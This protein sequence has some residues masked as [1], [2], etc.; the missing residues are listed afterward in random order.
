MRTTRT[1]VVAGA[2]IGGLTAALSLARAGY[3][4][5]VAERAKQL[6][7]GGAG[8]QL[9]PN[10]GRVLSELGLDEALDAAAVTPEAIEIRN[11]RSGAPIATIR[12]GDTVRKRHG[13][14]YRVVHRADLI[15]IL[16][17]AASDQPDVEVM[18]GAELVEFAAH[19]NGVTVML[20]TA[21]RQ[22]ELRASVLVAADGVNST[23]RASL[24]GASPPKATGRTAW[25][26]MLPLVDIPDHVPRNRTGLWLG[27]D[28]HL[29]HYPLRGGTELNIV[30]IVKDDQPSAGWNAPGDPDRLRRQLRRWSPFAQA[31]LARASGWRTW[32]ILAAS[33]DGPWVSGP[34]ALVGDAAHAMTPF[35]AQGGA[36]AI[37]DAAV[38]ARAL[39]AA[40]DD[41]HAALLR[42]QALRRPRV[43]RVWR[44]SRSAGDLYHL[45]SLASPIRDFGMRVL[46][47][48]SLLGS[49]SWI[50]GWRPE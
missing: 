34:V 35:L 40:P 30:A 18:L 46:S 25:R 20:G 41:R 21:G 3:R 17:R 7:G 28:A 8:I 32:P 14:P 6:A 38:L 27:P 47:R 44:R 15:A 12:L 5:V 26:A 24:P 49:H 45:D 50:Y 23:V 33:P 1:V 9:A 2:G 43:A 16:G 13:V 36:M 29:V 22:T 39:A 48:L 42:Y 4:V 11:G 37:E 10:A 31:I 19:R